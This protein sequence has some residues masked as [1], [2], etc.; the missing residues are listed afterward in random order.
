MAKKI[1]CATGK[2]VFV[3]KIQVVRAK[4]Q[5]LDKIRAFGVSNR[6]G[7]NS[8]RLFTALAHYPPLKQALAC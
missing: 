7:G 4:P 3:Y 6:T 5:R 8:H 1:R 2:Q